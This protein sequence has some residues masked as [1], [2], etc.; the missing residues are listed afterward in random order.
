MLSVKSQTP[1]ENAALILLTSG[2]YKGLIYK[3]LQSFD[4]KTPCRE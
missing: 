3:V 2:I 4:Y 1:K